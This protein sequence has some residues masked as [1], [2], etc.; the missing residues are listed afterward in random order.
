MAISPPPTFHEPLACRQEKP[1]PGSNA[2]I[3]PGGY[4]EPMGIVSGLSQNDTTCQAAD[5]I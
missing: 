4:F 3:L 5:K 1:L 2:D